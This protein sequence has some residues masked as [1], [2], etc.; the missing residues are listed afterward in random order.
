MTPE[1]L[2]ECWPEI[3]EIM[4]SIPEAETIRRRLAALDAKRTLTALG[5]PEEKLPELLRVAPLVRDRLTLMRIRRM[6]DL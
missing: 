2:T 6:L 3:R 1:R 5:V 4:A